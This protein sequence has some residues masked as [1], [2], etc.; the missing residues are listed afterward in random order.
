MGN[1]HPFDLHLFWFIGQQQ[2][3]IISLKSITAQQKNNNGMKR[4][5]IG[6]VHYYQFEQEQIQ[7]SAIYMLPSAIFAL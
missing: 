2:L 6:R 3:F 1:I 4:V 7:I 5:A